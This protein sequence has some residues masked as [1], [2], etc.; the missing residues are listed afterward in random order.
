MVLM[1]EG[2]LEKAVASED[3]GRFHLIDAAKYLLRTSADLAQ[4]S[5]SAL[6]PRNT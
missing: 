6:C 4:L 2:S 1:K 3:V 5:D